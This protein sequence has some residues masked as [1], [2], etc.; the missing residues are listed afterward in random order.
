MYFFLGDGL[1]FTGGKRLTWPVVITIPPPPLSL[2]FR[3]HP[4]SHTYDLLLRVGVHDHF[5]LPF[6]VLFCF[7][8][9]FPEL[10]CSKPSQSI[11]SV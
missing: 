2:Q 7:E 1:P 8:Q 6:F 3:I 11:P 9:I 10:Q 5:R 4:W